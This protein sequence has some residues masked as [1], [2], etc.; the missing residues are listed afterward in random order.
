MLMNN[1]IEKIQTEQKAPAL[2]KKIGNTTY[3][4]NIHFNENA[5]ETLH[6]ITSYSIHY[7]KLYDEEMLARLCKINEVWCLPISKGQ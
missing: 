6:V 1:T 7:T 5:K 2:V 3:V 4:V